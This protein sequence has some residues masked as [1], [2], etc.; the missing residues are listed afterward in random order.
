MSPGRGL[1]CVSLAGGEPGGQL[2][3][4]QRLAPRADVVEIRL[5]TLENPD[6]GSW[7]ATMERPLLFTNRPAWEGGNFSGPEEQR[8]ALLA[9]AI[10]LDAAYIDLELATEPE[11]RLALID[12]ARDKT[13]QVIVSSH[14]FKATPPQ[15]DLRQTLEQMMA[16]G[17]DCGKIVTTAQDSDD[18]IRVLGLLEIAHQAAFPLSAF[19]MGGPG[20]ISRFAGLYLGGFMNYV[21]LDQASATAPG[22]LSAAHCQSLIQLFEDYAD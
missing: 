3:E 21:A 13:T 11:R 15:A 10:E 7:L 20:R 2:Q 9:R 22:Q 16:S 8:L 14:D 17:A 12:M 6:I 19:C 5:D 18:V 1:V 4:L